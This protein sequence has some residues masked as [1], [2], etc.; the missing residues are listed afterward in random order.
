MQQLGELEHL[1]A[2]AVVREHHLDALPGDQDGR[3]RQEQA[4]AEPQ[5]LRLVDRQQVRDGLL[6]RGQEVELHDDPPTAPYGCRQVRS[7]SPVPATNAAFAAR[8]SRHVTSCMFIAAAS[9]SRARF[10]STSSCSTNAGQEL[11]ARLPL[12]RADAGP[13]R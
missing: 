12:P 5:E 3:E 1:V 9:A 6:N 2:E 11:A 10:V 13:R 4:V 8:P 7:A